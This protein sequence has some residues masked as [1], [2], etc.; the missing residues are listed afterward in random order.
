MRKYAGLGSVLL[1]I[2]LLINF[3]IVAP[4]VNVIGNH[5]ILITSLLFLLS[6]IL[7][8]L[9]P[10]GLYRKIAFSSIVV[11]IV[12]FLFFYVLMAVLWSQP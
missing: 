5:I 7:A 11:V 4:D 10:Q 3:F 2:L 12:W 8:F 9:S 1:L 6:V